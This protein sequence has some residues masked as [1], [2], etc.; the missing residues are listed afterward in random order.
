MLYVFAHNSACIYQIFDA[1][2]L[3][4]SI[5][6]ETF[7][8]CQNFVIFVYFELLWGSKSKC[9]NLEFRILRKYFFQEHK[10]K[11]NVDKR[12]SLAIIISKCLSYTFGELFW[13][14][15]HYNRVKTDWH[16]RD[17]FNMTA[18]WLGGWV[19]WKCSIS[20]DNDDK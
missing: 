6:F 15:K 2:T 11:K 7:Y 14:A 19:V 12:L 18:S 1:Y 17:H 9:E 10:T 16:I 3:L 5:C 8:I 13:C 20:D 4:F